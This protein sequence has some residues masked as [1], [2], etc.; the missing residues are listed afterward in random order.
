MGMESV[1]GASGRVRPDWDRLLEERGFVRRLA[2]G[3][4]RDPARADDLEQE[5][6][7]RALERPP[8]E[9]SAARS[10]F[11][12]VLRRLA[13]RA[14]R[15]EG[16]R[17]R[18]EHAVARSEHVLPGPDVEGRLRLERDLVQAVEGLREPY[19]TTV[20]LRYFD[21][22]SPR[23]IAA[24]QGVPVA[25][26]KTR[27]RRALEIL[28]Q[29]MDGKRERRDWAL[30]L[31]RIGKPGAG[32]APAVA[33]VGGAA[34]GLLGTATWFALRPSG[35]P[36]LP[37]AA[38]PVV[39]SAEPATLAA[40]PRAR[41]REPRPSAAVGGPPEER[42]AAPVAARVSAAIR[43]R[44]PDAALEWRG[45]VL[46]PGGN[47]VADASVALGDLRARADAF[48]FFVLP[49]QPQEEETRSLFGG[50]QEEG[51]ALV[52]W[53]DGWAPAVLERAGERVVDARARRTELAEVELVLP[54]P[55]L[56]IHGVVID[57]EGRAAR[58]WRV[59]LLDGTP[60]QRGRYRPFMA[61]E[62]ASGI[63]SHVRIDD[64]TF[65]FGGLDA[66]RS[67]RV[68]AWCPKTLE[69]LV[70]EPIPAGT[71]NA[72]LRASADPWRP[73]VDGVVVG[74]DGSPLEGVRCRLSMNEYRLEGSSWM[75]TA[76]EVSTDADGRFAFHDVPPS[77]IFVRFNLGGAG[78][79]RDLPPEDPGRGLRVSLVRSGRF[80]FESA[81]GGVDALAVLDA[82]GERMTISR[83]LGGG[84]TVGT[85]RL[86][87]AP[88]GSAE[89]GVSELAR[90]LV[91]FEGEREIER[92]ALKVVPGE[93]VQV[94]R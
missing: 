7:Q 23:A 77:P 1:H 40:P 94:R 47:G 70:S 92:Q 76:E 26:V 28:R 68:R 81:P 16:R 88:D 25:T 93:T 18:R 21:D 91:V 29:S 13:G 15:E 12:T 14:A 87:V 32:A 75:N 41:V 35:A 67:Y 20:F 27:L 17:L 59:A 90:W 43:P 69:Q 85:T 2:R 3:L 79:Q 9:A 84:H 86:E 49:I 64:G 56:E 48:G 44:A 33:L 8:R 62:L 38:V 11:G 60:V 39:A 52:A 6:W 19:R 46:F 5:A 80:R 66:A 58:G 53:C 82:A 55:A 63:D 61:E 30:A 36:G 45:R 42:E 54:A 83:D 10:W 73:L 72:I 89:G 57:H 71:R 78:T 37:P 65:S 22:L 31:L 51:T 4:V 74:L 50:F 34:L 24:R